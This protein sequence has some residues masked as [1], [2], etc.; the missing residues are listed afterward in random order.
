MVE[1]DFSRPQ[2]RLEREGLVVHFR[3][4][5]EDPIP[6]IRD[7]SV[8]AGV[9][10]VDFALFVVAHGLCQQPKGDVTVR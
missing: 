1:T 4:E 3:V 5:D 9:H 10:F 7:I 6:R 2:R 8:D